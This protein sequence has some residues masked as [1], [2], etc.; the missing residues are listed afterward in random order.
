[1]VL[2][3][4][5]MVLL[6]L[7]LVAFLMV[8][9]A[10]TWWFNR[11][12]PGLLYLALLGA[13]TGLVGAFA[14]PTGAL[15]AMSG[16]DLPRH[17]SQ[18]LALPACAVLCLAFAHEIGGGPVARP[19]TGPLRWLAWGWMVGG[20][21]ALAGLVPPGWLVLM[22]VLT[23]TATMCATAILD[24]D[25]AHARGA[26]LCLTLAWLVLLGGALMHLGTPHL[27]AAPLPARQALTLTSGF[28]LVLL[29]FALADH[30]WS[31]R[32]RR[33]EEVLNRAREQQAGELARQ[34][35]SDRYRLLAAVSHDLRQ[36]L[37]AIS[38]AAQTLLRQRPLRNP[39]PMLAQLR[40]AIE[41][42]DALLDAI[43]TV[44]LLETGSI[45][46]RMA[47]FSMQ[48]LLERID[49]QF[50]PQA[51]AQG[52]R[53]TVTPSI[54]WAWS[55]PALLERM[56]TNLVSNAVLYTRQGGV[57]VSCRRRGTELLVQVWDTGPGFGVEHLEHVFE[58][59][60]RGEPATDTDNGV[61]LGLAIVR[62]S[63]RV[64]GIQL[65]MRTRPGH[66]SCFSLRVPVGQAPPDVVGRIVEDLSRS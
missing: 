40:G 27:S 6:F 63:A 23:T 38:L 11:D 5:P 12:R 44:A 13:F 36:P 9:G 66:G 29:S 28:A 50:A 30:R 62:Q 21:L 45:K 10:T 7:L 19:F 42:A 31:V 3:L 15:H 52:L 33:H 46:A 65:T 4:D 18:A 22:A 25:L 24:L 57:L 39:G 8:Q 20:V 48:P 2:A 61:G 34:A 56:I 60:F 58:T 47:A 1:M 43:N 35:L 32:R 26:A 54:E 59:H 64:L 51:E 49:R 37:Y 14:A 17:L 55:D 41:S 53:W 16:P